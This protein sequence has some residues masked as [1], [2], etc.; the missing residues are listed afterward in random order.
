MEYDGLTE[1]L[2]KM[3]D[4]YSFG[5]KYSNKEYLKLYIPISISGSVICFYELRWINYIE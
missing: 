2:N 1:F 4:N 5:S 3:Q